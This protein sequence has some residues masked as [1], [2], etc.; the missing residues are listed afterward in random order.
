MRLIMMGTGPFAV[1]TFERLLGS[2]HEVLAL[3]TRP[4]R[5][6]H[7]KSRAEANP[8]RELALARG[9]R[10][11]EPV[12]INAP[13]ARAVLASDRPDLFVACDYG[14]ILSTEVLEIARAGGVNLHASLLPK[15]RGAAPIN[16]AI[17]HGE[18]ETGVTVIHMTPRLDAGPA[19]VQR[20]TPIGQDET[21][22]ELEPRLAQL[23]A[24]AVL[25]AIDAL[26]AGTARAI[27][28]DSARATRAPR[29]KKEDGAVD[30]SRSVVQIHDQVRALQPW[31]T[32][33]TFWHRSSGEPLRLILER[34]HPDA[35]GAAGVSPGPTGVSPVPGTI[36][37]AHASRLVV[38]AGDGAL[39]IDELQPAGK[40]KLSA[41]EF[42]RGY[43]LLPGDR[44]GPK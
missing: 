13:P 34:V 39:V 4:P 1:P 25:E 6:V 17:Y 3:V 24:R 8:M 35:L 44:L 16:W 12:D 19:I 33:Y 40:R 30:W 11:H 20:A 36:L 38:R 37:E 22:A 9:I 32:T 10:V 27:E 31:P 29:L 14:Q 18:A 23:G 2:R 42:L 21:A 43:G 15:Y 7:G 28:Q 26:E 5:P 41:A